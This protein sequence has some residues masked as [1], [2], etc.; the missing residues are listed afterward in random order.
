MAKCTFC[1]TIIEKGTG[2]MYVKKDATTYFFCSTK[3]EKN[4]LKLKRKPRTTL[5]TLEHA[6]EKKAGKL[7]GSKSKDKKKKKKKPAKK[8]KT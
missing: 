5:W 3:C 8:K 7:G 4:L 6:K 1:G 2:T